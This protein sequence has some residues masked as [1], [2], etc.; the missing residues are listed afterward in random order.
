MI[1]RRVYSNLS[2]NESG[3]TLIELIV[4]ALVAMLV[5]AGIVATMT[6]SQRN[7]FVQDRVSEAQ[8][9]GRIS[10]ELVARDV[11][12]AGL[13]YPRGTADKLFW[14]PAAGGGGAIVGIAVPG[15]VGALNQNNAP[16][17]AQLAGTDAVAIK[18]FH[19]DA[20]NAEPIRVIKHP[21]PPAVNMQLEKPT[22]PATP[23]AAGDILLCETPD[24]Q[25]T[26]ICV[27]NIN[28]AAP[29]FDLMVGNAGGAGACPQGFNSPGGPGADY[30]NG[31]CRKLQQGTTTTQVYYVADATVAGSAPVGRLMFWNGD[32]AVNPVVVANDVEDFQ[33]AYC[34]A[35]CD[36]ALPTWNWTPSTAGGEDA[37]IRLVRISLVTR[38]AAQDP[39]FS[40]SPA[41]VAATTPTPGFLEDHPLLAALDG[42]RRRLLN[43]TVQVRN[44]TLN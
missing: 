37:N 22:A 24:G 5:L 29:N 27:T 25:F 44:N 15:V 13:L 34:T 6:M 10:L 12:L 39:K 36:T 7:Y 31:S 11:R 38:T 42:F 30:T 20:T 17:G 16:A 41:S 8:Q 19:P 33:I 2:G 23:P 43:T 14:Y 21:A 40:S 32:G 26:T 1:T 9:G 18:S 3:F 35:N 4:G 28:T